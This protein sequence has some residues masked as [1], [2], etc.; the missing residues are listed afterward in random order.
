MLNHKTIDKISLTTENALSF[1]EV[2]FHQFYHHW[3]RQYLNKEIEL[4]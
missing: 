2:E 4:L 3:E 1:G